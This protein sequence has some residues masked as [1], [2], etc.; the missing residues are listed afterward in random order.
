MWSD[1]IELLSP[2]HNQGFGSSQGKE[3]LIIKH[4]VAHLAG[5]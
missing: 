5:E 3:D 4:F 1:G 2:T